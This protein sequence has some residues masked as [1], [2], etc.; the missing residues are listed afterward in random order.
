MSIKIGDK[1]K[2]TDKSQKFGIKIKLGGLDNL[3]IKII[4]YIIDRTLSSFDLIEIYRNDKNLIYTIYR[5]D[6]KKVKK[7]S[8][9]RR[10]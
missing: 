6:L 8:K 5:K 10:L 3:K 9:V 2:I 7:N 4:I 1:V